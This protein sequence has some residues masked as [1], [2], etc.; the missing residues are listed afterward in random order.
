M[1]S[2]YANTKFAAYGAGQVPALQPQQ[3]AN[4]A[5]QQ[6]MQEYAQGFGGRPVPAP[7]LA[8]GF[9][10]GA[11]PYGQGM[12]QPGLRPGMQPGVQP[13]A[14]PARPTTLNEG[15]TSITDMT[16]PLLGNLA[17]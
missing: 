13:A 14:P 7:G 5:M 3:P 15:V 12:V 8:P 11:T 2:F 9:A 17:P 4:P 10:P 1:Q 16:A 6:R